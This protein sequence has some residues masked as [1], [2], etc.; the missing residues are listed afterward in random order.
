MAGEIG[1]TPAVL[2][3][4][5]ISCEGKEQEYPLV[6]QQLLGR[7]TKQEIPDLPIL[8]AY[9]SR[10]HGEFM[11]SN[12]ESSY[13]D[14]GSKNGTY[15]NGMK[16]KPDIFYPLKD[17][18]ILRISREIT[19]KYTAGSAPKL[20][21]DYEGPDCGFMGWQ[22][23][24]K[25]PLGEDEDETEAFT[26]GTESGT[27]HRI[28]AVILAVLLVLLFLICAIV[29]ICFQN[30]HDKRYS[31]PVNI[32]EEESGYASVSG[33]DTDDLWGR[34]IVYAKEDDEFR[35]LEMY[36]AQDT[37]VYYSIVPD[38]DRFYETAYELYYADY[39]QEQDQLMAKEEILNQ[40]DYMVSAAE[41]LLGKSPE[42]AGVCLL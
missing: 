2:P 21:I 31:E 40:F 9:A 20:W 15:L 18:D 1:P 8:N 41:H 19:I 10:R 12:G 38:V 36:D 25:D 16:L 29:L 14:L 27:H 37:Q 5:T 11:T 22:S 32:A 34:S 26:G 33:S 23:K 42:E 6:G 7:L 28:I 24:S 3:R 4:I 30:G 39:L 35:S 17:G 13:R